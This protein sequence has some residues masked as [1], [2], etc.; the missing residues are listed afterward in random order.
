VSDDL[1]GFGE[2]LRLARERLELRQDQLAALVGTDAGSISRWE[3]GKGH[4]QTQQLAKLV[5]ALGE[6]LD[7]LV[8]GVDGK[9][10]RQMSPAFM[11]FLQTEYGRMAQ[12]RHYLPTL[13]SVRTLGEPTVKF[14]Q[15]LTASLRLLDPD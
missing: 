14:Y 15:A 3:R 1:D 8:L 6:S 11:E 4:P 12:E 7:Y 10:P 5:T 2:R 13:L 9:G